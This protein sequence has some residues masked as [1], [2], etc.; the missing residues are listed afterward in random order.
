MFCRAC[1]LIVLLFWLL[2]KTCF[3]RAKVL[4]HGLMDVCIRENGQWV[5]LMDKEKKQTQMVLCVMMV[6]GSTIRL[7]VVEGNICNRE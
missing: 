1:E 3:N 4:V 6:F 2:S 7:F 5:K